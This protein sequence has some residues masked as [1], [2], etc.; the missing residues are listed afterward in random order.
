VC[1]SL[2]G[3][4]VGLGDHLQDLVDDEDEVHS[5]CE[6]TAAPVATYCLKK[7]PRC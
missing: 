4:L 1:P 5:V 2:V 3:G 7:A 6:E